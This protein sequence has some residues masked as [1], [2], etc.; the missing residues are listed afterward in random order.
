MF[1]AF[2]ADNFGWVGELSRWAEV[3][4]PVFSIVN[5]LA[6]LVAT[7][8][9]GYAA[10]VI[11]RLRSDVAVLHGELDKR[12]ESEATRIKAEK[13]S[14][15]ISGLGSTMLLRG[16]KLTVPTA[17]IAKGLPTYNNRETLLAV[18]DLR[19][20]VFSRARVCA[21]TDEGIHWPDAPRLVWSDFVKAKIGPTED[22]N[23]KIGDTLLQIGMRGEKP[24]INLFNELQAELRSV[25]PT[26]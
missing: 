1:V 19:G 25:V 24:Y 8:T 6:A 18:I 16:D 3:G 4:K 23:I 14:Q 7:G 9:S 10:W 2:F 11:R 15:V 26:T 5:F 13:I 21:L 22:L 17:S 20:R 12:R